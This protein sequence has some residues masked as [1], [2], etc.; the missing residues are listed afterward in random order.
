MPDGQ[1]KKGLRDK[2]I[3][4]LFYSTGVRCDEMARLT[5][6]DVDHGNELLRVRYGKGARERVVPAGSLACAAVRAY[7]RG[8]RTLWVAKRPDE[9]A[10]WL[11]AIH[12]HQ[13]MG[14]QAIAVMAKSYARAAGLERPGRTHL[15]RHTCATH[16]VAAGAGIA[17]VQRLLGHQSL[18]TTQK[19][20]RVFPNDVKKM[21]ARLHPRAAVPASAVAPIPIT[22]R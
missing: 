1:T 4:E 6:D 8:A 3:L 7:L 14:K 15:W 2:A 5:V 17:I 11:A 21:H 9:G 16:L 20:T 12:P 13:P 19:Y 18:R 22:Q 10:L